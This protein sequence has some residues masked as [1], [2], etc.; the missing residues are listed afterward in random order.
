[1]RCSGQLR[2]RTCLHG[3]PLALGAVAVAVGGGNEGRV[4]GAALQP[5]DLTRQAHGLAGVNAAISVHRR[6]GIEHGAV[7]QRPAHRDGVGAT[8]HGGRDVLGNA[9][10]CMHG[11]GRENI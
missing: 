3:N 11:Q 5:C 6:A 10:D 1:M 9:W 4:G 2:G 7:G 8:V